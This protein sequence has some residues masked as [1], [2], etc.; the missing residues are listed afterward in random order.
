LANVQICENQA[1]RLFPTGE[2]SYVV[3]FQSASYFIICLRGEKTKRVQHY[4]LD[5]SIILILV[6]FC[7][8]PLKKKV[9]LLVNAQA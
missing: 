8:P 2:L 6:N 3:I 9:H 7:H 1:A 5:N 4:I